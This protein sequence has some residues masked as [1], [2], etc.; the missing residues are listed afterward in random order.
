MIPLPGWRNIPS[1]KILSILVF[2]A[3]LGLVVSVISLFYL[4]QHLVSIKTNEIDKHRS[5]L[6]VEGAV[7]TSVNRVLS[8]VLDNSIWDDAVKQTYTPHLDAHWLYDS[9]GSGFK[10]NNLYDGTFILDENYRILWGAFRSEPFTESDIGFFGSGLQTLI[11][12]HADVLRRGKNAFAGI[13][14]TRAGIAFVGIGLI[15]PTIGRLPIYDKTRRYLV[16]TRHINPTML[17]TLGNT[18]QINRLHTTQFAGEYSVPLRT[19]GGETLA[20]LSWQPRLPGAEAARA[21]SNSIRLIAILAASLILLFIMLSS[22]GLYK[23]ARGEQQAR[24]N[25]L[26]D[27]LSLL[28]NRRALIERLNAMGECGKNEMQS[29]VFID[30]DGFKDVNDNYGHDTGDALIAHIARELRD[31]VPA[32]AMLARMGGDE[33]AMTMSGEHAVNQASAFALAVLELLKTPV[34]LSALKIYISASIGIASGVPTQCSSTE[35]FRRADMAMYHAKKS[36]KGR[37]AWYDD[38][39]NET[40]QHQLHIEN[41]IREGLEKGEFDVWYQ[42]IVNAETLVMEGVEA[43]L[44]WPRRPEGPLAPDAFIPIAESSGLIYAL[45][46]FALSQACYDLETMGDLLLS[47]NISPAQFRDPEFETRVIQ[48]LGRCQFPAR[49]LQ[50]EV[51]ESYVL[52]NPERARVAIENLKSLGIA[53]ALDDFGIGYSSIGYLRSCRFDSLKIDKSLAGVVDVDPQAAELVRGTVRIANALGI[54]VV[55]EGVE[56]QQQLALL[57][58]AGC[59]RLQGYYFSQPMPIDSLL[60]LRQQQG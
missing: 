18:F 41:G 26:I 49:R 24:K 7:Q 9:W 38:T 36:G 48:T 54:T 34:A 55:A 46:Q 39:L 15:R 58:R 40:R 45:G 16:I 19:E 42:P 27:W 57:R 60:Q 53:V 20:Y 4:S 30:L 2:L 23:L 10:I 8:L 1:A 47:V 13:T 50:L 43:L 56:T 25:A 51:T 11:E 28:P 12:Q 21:A 37:A 59:D 29:V 35:L 3:G 5:M 14:R 17:E 22:L 31:R 52:E 44:R 33:F 32:G 6:S